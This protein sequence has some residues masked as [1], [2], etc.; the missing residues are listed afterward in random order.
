MKK[1]EVNSE[2]ETWNNKYPR[3]GIELPIGWFG[4]PYDNI[5]KLTFLI[6]RNHKLIFEID[7]QL[8]LI[9]TKPISI[10]IEE[11]KLLIKNWKQFVFDR[12]GYGN[13]TPTC[14]VFKSGTVKLIGYPNQ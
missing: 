14:D 8:Y 4:R 9:F 1:A 10:E 5:H 6:E 11:S 12:Q 2:I 7:N 3:F 13:M